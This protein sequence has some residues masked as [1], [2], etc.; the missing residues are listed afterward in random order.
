MTAPSDLTGDLSGDVWEDYEAASRGQADAARP[1]ASA[2]VEANA[3]S[4]KTKVLIDRV[5][6]LLLRRAEPDSILCVTYTKAAASEMQSRLFERLGGWCVMDADKLTDDL[7]KLE[8][9]AREDYTAE[10]IGRARELFAKALETP[11]GLRIETIHAFCGRVLRRFPLEAGIAP[12]FDEL[13]ENDSRDLWDDAFRAMGRRVV[14]G[15]AKLVEA[16]RAAAEAGGG[17]GFDAVRALLPRRG[18]VERFIAEAGGV[19]RASDKLRGEIGAGETA[20]N[21]IIE[22]AMGAELPREDLKRAMAAFA[23]G[24]KRDQEQAA[25]IAV[26]LSD[27]EADDRYAALCKVIY[28]GKGELK[29][30]GSVFTKGVA[31]ANPILV[32]LFDVDSPQG[33]ETLRILAAKDAYN[34]RRIFERSDAVLRLAQVLFEDFGRRKRARAGLDF[35]DLIETA[36]RLL[37]RRHAAEWVLWKLDGGISH[38]LLDEA[39]DTSPAQWR[40][41]KA[42]TDDIFAGAGAVRDKARTLFVVGDQKQSIYSFQG[43]DPEHFLDETQQFEGRS[44]AAKIEFT[45][46]NLAMSFRSA[47]EILRYVDEVFDTTVFSPDAPFSMHPPEADNILRHTPF[48]RA[49]RGSVELWPLEPKPDI[50]PAQPWDAPL[51]QETAASPKALLARRIAQFIKREIETGASVWDRKELRPALPGDF[52][53]LVRGRTGGLFDAILQALKRENLPVAGADR[54]QLLDSLAVQDLLNLVRFALCPEDDLALAEILKGPFAAFKEG[55]ETGW[56]EDDDL[57]AIANPRKGALW[58]EVL[59]AKDSKLAS[60]RDF[61][62]DVLAR[63]H[64]APFEF[65]T[66]A[67]ERGH[68]LARPGWELILS[69]FGGPAREPV[70]ALVDRAAAFDADNAPSL[71]LFLDAVE[72]RGGEVKRELSGPQGEVRVMTVHGAKGLEAPVVIL[73]DTCSAHRGERDGL[74]ISKSGAPVWAGSAKNDVKYSAELRADADGRALREHR[75]L[76]YVALTRAQDRLVVAGA[77]AGNSK[78]GHANTSWYGVCENAMLRLEITGAAQR[79]PQEDRQALR[80]G[81]APELMLPAVISLKAKTVLPAWLRNPAPAEMKG[82][83]LSPSGLV[84]Q[85]EPP[86]MTPFGA[87]REARLRRGR[88]IH[89]LFQH[90][91]GLPEK[92]R[93]KAA[94][95]FLR[96]QADLAPTQRKEMADAAMGVLED[97]RF[98]AVFGPGG[99][100]EAPV[101]GRIGIGQIGQST[102]NGRVDRLV[103]ADKEI[104]IIDYKT[105]RPAP[106]V[107][108][109]VGEAYVAQMAAYRAVLSSRWPDRPI[110]CLLV[111][112]DGPKLMEIPASALDL[113]IKAV[114]A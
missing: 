34:A 89:L 16:A 62:V 69:R 101:I 85:P 4:G 106:L 33:R 87:E 56:L 3:G 98:A 109:E 50:P 114:R 37:T 7:A 55:K 26:A 48:R 54:I 92:A 103:I 5:A 107:V 30:R 73:P 57:F 90:L 81:D 94:E 79:V 1:E 53:I 14:R 27:Q 96:R 21:E 24:G 108:G 41:L 80:L 42:L 82:R 51:G 93:R 102:I 15:D 22:R 104:L 68:G 66:H 2:W 72:R 60:V 78:A 84:A 43:A 35:D 65:L 91:P 83:V 105:D 112:T 17:K 52:L 12:G 77:F 25:C 23:T 46:P 18:A 11:G 39:Q 47:P 99:R 19:E 95:A 36:G 29:A 40:I 49:E 8:G 44:R 13:D 113:A 100:P 70:T 9:R 111:W 64:Q 75:R 59:R 97:K 32:D 31:T 74:F 45:L 28:T 20:S 110:R 61:L 67:L 86:V 88:L 63:R 6:R 38:I 76:L 71:Q 58:A 10:E